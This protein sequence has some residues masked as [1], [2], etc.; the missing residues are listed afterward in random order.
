MDIPNRP[1][2]KFDPDSQ[3]WV[4]W[5]F[6]QAADFD[7]GIRDIAGLAQVPLHT[8]NSYRNVTG[9]IATGKAVFRAKVAQEMCSFMFAD[10]A[11]I[12]D[13]AERRHLQTLQMDALKHWTKLE[14]KREE[15]ASFKDD[16]EKDREALTKLSTEEL[17]AK[18]RELLK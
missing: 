1:K 6:H 9:V 3:Q 7:L 18:A 8:F 15:M 17:K 16:K 2:G 10:L 13:P 5:V 14:Q 11:C 4:E 12:E